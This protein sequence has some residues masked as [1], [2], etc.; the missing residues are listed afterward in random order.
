MRLVRAAL[1]LVVAWCTCAQPMAAAAREIKLYTH[2]ACPFAQRVWIALEATGLP[3]SK[4][5]VNLYGSGGFDKTQLKRVEAAGGLSP[6]KGY[7]PVLAIGDEVIRESSVCVE[8]IAAL[9]TEEAG[10]T[11]LLPEEK[12]RAAKLIAA[13]NALPTRSSSRELSALLR[14]CD[15]ACA[16]SPYLAGG[17]FSIADACLLPFLQRVEDDIPSELGRLRGY[18]GRMHADP[19]F[20]KPVMSS[21]W[22]WW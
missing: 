13:C 7:I 11:S 12:E 6:P 1:F 17:S 10:A 5:D 3:F 20:S 14:Q 4:V 18:M 16:I 8:R 19:A 15:E 21:W 9:S 22:W 2:T